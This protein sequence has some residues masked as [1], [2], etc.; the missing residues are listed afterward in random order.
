VPKKLPVTGQK[1]QGA[2]MVEVCNVIWHLLMIS[3]MNSKSF[4]YLEI[5]FIK[6]ISKATDDHLQE[7]NFVMYVH[8]SASNSLIIIKL[9][10][11]DL[12]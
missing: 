2:S 1:L 6:C 9:A 5:L 7:L 3:I 10:V 11:I 8:P 12:L 4:S